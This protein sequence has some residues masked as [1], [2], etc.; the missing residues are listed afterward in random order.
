MS[1]ETEP[2]E[3]ADQTQEAGAQVLQ[4]KGKVLEDLEVFEWPHTKGEMGLRLTHFNVVGVPET[5]GDEKE[6]QGKLALVMI[7]EIIRLSQD[8]HDLKEAVKYLSL[9]EHIHGKGKGGVRGRG[10]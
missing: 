3:N 8:V 10:F 5:V 4:P 2:Q 1:S 6:E 7:S 9:Q